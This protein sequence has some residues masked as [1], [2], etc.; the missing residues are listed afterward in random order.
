MRSSGCLARRRSIRT[1]MVEEVK[2]MSE[3]RENL[4]AE[5]YAIAMCIEGLEPLADNPR[6]LHRVFDFIGHRYID[7]LQRQLVRLDA[8]IKVVSERL[9]QQKYQTTDATT[10]KGVRE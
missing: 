9:A 8:E 3:T 2:G 6:A 7:N 4:D 5:M 1:G 10:N